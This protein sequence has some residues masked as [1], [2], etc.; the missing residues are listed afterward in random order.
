MI[1]FVQPRIAR[2]MRERSN[3]VSKAI[4]AAIAY[5]LMVAAP[6][7]A[8]PG[9]PLRVLMAVGGVDYNTSLV[10][11]LKKHPEIELTVRDVEEDGVVFTRRALSEV[12]AVLMY[13]RDDVAEDEERDALLGFL[14]EEGGVVVLH[15]AIANYPE[16]RDWWRDHVGGLYVLAGSSAFPPSAYFRDFKGVAVPMAD[17]P[18]TRRLG[19]AWRYEDES[20]D[21]LWVSDEVSVLLY[22][23]AFGSAA[24]VAWIGPSSSDRVVFVQPGHGER[25]LTDPKY[26][27]LIEDALR[28][29]ARSRK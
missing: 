27:M 12:D 11:S 17:H 8:A 28:W 4:T 15:H 23:T 20:Y 19:G 24:Q 6:A 25:V 26:L 10:R 7:N 13:H 22:T 18:I 1:V 5:A 9:E 14:A 3:A 16:W 29:A 21:R 2:V